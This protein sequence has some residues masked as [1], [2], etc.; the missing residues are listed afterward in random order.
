MGKM[1][2]Y[3]CLGYRSWKSHVNFPVHFESR[4]TLISSAH[5]G[6]KN[7]EA[8]AKN[9]LDGLW[10]NSLFRKAIHLLWEMV[11]YGDTC[12][13]L[14]LGHW[15]PLSCVISYNLYDMYV[16]NFQPDTTRTHML[17]K[18]PMHSAGSI[19]RKTICHVECGLHWPWGILWPVAFMQTGLN[20]ESSKSLQKI[21]FTLLLNFKAASTAK[22]TYLCIR[23]RIFTREHRKL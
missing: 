1:H 21:F 15:Y 19:R 18:K 17:T 23:K 12:S 4:Y 3:K 16:S 9:A 20:K 5:W 14:Q 10:E 6:N 8:A 22:A 13:V 7:A 11:C 2:I